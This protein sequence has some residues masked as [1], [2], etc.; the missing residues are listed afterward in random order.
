MAAVVAVVAVAAAV[1]KRG[2]GKGVT[3][4][5]R[6]REREKDPHVPRVRPAPLRLR[7]QCAGKEKQRVGVGRLCAKKIDDLTLG[8][9]SEALTKMPQSHGKAARAKKEGGPEPPCS[10]RPPPRSCSK[11]L[12]KKLAGGT[13]NNNGNNMNKKYSAHR[14]FPSKGSPRRG[15]RPKSRVRAQIGPPLK[16][17]KSMLLHCLRLQK[18]NIDCSWEALCGGARTHLEFQTRGNLSVKVALFR[19][20]SGTHESSL[21]S[22]DEPFRCGFSEE[23]IV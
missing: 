5:Q 11:C 23:A 16:Q 14:I 13:W 19:P 18:F 12:V 4:M 8:L 6:E 22:R 17:Q 21:V 10:T 20:T 9:P 15:I 3:H 2:R 1:K 7:P